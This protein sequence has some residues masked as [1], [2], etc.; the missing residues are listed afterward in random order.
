VARV[1]GIAFECAFA[2]LIVTSIPRV[3]DDQ[4]RQPQGT[5]GS[6]RWRR[7]KRRMVFSSLGMECSLLTLLRFLDRLSE[8]M[9]IVGVSQLVTCNSAT[10]ELAFLLQ[11][12]MAYAT[13]LLQTRVGH[14]LRLFASATSCKA[15]A[16]C[17]PGSN[18][19]Q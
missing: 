2:P 10:L 17:F 4:L 19:G 16:R 8:S 12:V 3:M 11:H 15:R 5:T 13:S 1:F 7:S 9:G 18:E 6:L 14:D